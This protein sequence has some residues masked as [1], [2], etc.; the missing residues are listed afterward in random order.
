MSLGKHRLY[1]CLSM[2]SHCPNYTHRISTVSPGLTLRCLISVPPPFI[3]FLIF[4]NP[5]TLLGPPFIN[6]KKIEFITGLLC[7]FLSLLELFTP[8]FQGKLTCFCV[9]FSFTLCGSLF[10]F[11]P[12]LY[13]DFKSF[14]RIPTPVYFNPPPVY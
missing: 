9:Y 1:I 12:L 6:F 14:C 10:L 13:N 8:N 11:Y 3:K 2:F 7:Y 4:S 5:R